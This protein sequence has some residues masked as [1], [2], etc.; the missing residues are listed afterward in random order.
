MLHRMIGR[1]AGCVA[2]VAML[3]PLTGCMGDASASTGRP[4]SGGETD[5]SIDGESGH[6]TS[7][8]L[9]TVTAG[10]DT[11]RGFVLDNVLHSPDDGDIHFHIHVPDSYDGSEPVALFLTLPGYQGLY[12]QGVGENLRTEEFGFEAQRYDERM[13]V[14]APQ[15]SDWGDTSARQTVALTEYLLDAY[16]IDPSRVFAEG[17]SGGGETMSR[18]MGMRP[19]LFSAYLHCSSRWD[20]DVQTLVDSETPV[21]LVVGQNDEYYG[22]GP[23]ETAYEQIHDLYARRGLSE[24]RIGELL[25]LDVK[26]A[27]Y[28]ADQG[29]TNQHGGGLLFSRDP[30]IMG[31]LFDR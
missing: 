12:F 7:D 28:F 16:A 19:D 31:W 14:V 6:G 4:A 20:G 18:V 1:L 29:V 13:I 24:D 25:V 30:S 5:T 11:Y 17:Y 9:G 26:D 10:T 8:D 2:C 27:G 22:S 3:M 23:S 15:L 21:Y